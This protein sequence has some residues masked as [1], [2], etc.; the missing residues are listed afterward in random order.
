MQTV[1]GVHKRGARR[2]GGGV[3]DTTVM[4]ISIKMY[5]IPVR[6]SNLM[7]NQI[8]PNIS[9]SLS[10]SPL[11]LQ[12]TKLVSHWTRTGMFL[13]FSHFRVTAVVFFLLGH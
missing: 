10:L 13:M 11:S 9:L 2:D 8:N 1:T 3:G 7:N 4:W 12:L 6:G 5:V